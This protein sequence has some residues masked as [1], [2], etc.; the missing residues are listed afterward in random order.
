MNNNSNVVTSG[1]VRMIINI[2]ILILGII[3]IANPAAALQ[4][5]TIT[6]GILLVVYGGIMIALHE[7]KRGKGE[8]PPA[9][10]WPIV[11]MIVGVLLLV[12]VN[13]ASK[14]LLPLVIG[15]WMIVLGLMNLRTAHQIRLAG[16]KSHTFALIVAIAEIVLGI[17]ALVS[18]AYSGYALGVMIGI[19][20]VIYGVASIISWA[21]N[22]MAFKNS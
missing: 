14:W 7:I 15:A 6:L 5:V 10:G 1:S 2:L 21:V 12:F 16:G 17:L 22:F 13:S 9:L 3:F 18:M 11:W 19:C 20:M 8:T 4:G